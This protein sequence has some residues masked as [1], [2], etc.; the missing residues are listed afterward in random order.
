VPTTAR[1]T[2][3][4]STRLLLLALVPAIGALA[5]AAALLWYL[6]PSLLVSAASAPLLESAALLARHELAAIPGDAPLQPLV[7]RIAGREDLRLTVIAPDGTV[8]ADSEVDADRI[9]ALEN[10]ASRPE[11]REAL[12]SRRGRGSAARA[13]ATTGVD[14]VYAAVTFTAEDGT[15]R[16]LRLAEPIEQLGALRSRLLGALAAAAAVALAA[17]LALA[18]WLSRRLFHPLSEL[19]DGATRLA[20]GDFRHRL[21]APKE[22]A[23]DKLAGALNRL[24]STVE[25]QVAAVAAE[26]DHLREILASMAEGVVVTD[27]RGRANLANPAFAKLFGLRGEVA[28]KSL[29]ELTRL[30]LLAD[31]AQAALRDRQAITRELEL[32]A[33]A[34]R[35]LALAAAP[36]AGGQGAVI[37]VS[38]VTA[39]V[40]IAEMRRDF[41]A[42]V[43]HELKTPL[44]AIRGYAETLAD[45]ALEDQENAGRF[46]TRILDQCQRLQALLAD[47]LTLSR[48]ESIDRNAVSELVDCNELA[49]DAVEEV[50]PLAA[51][52]QVTVTWKGADLPALHGDAEGLERML[53]NLV[54]NAVKY[55]RRGGEVH[56]ELARRADQVVIEVRDTGIGI[57]EAALPRIFERF[58]RVDKGRSR[59]EG[60]TGLGLAIVKHAAQAHGGRVEV[61]SEPGQ[62]SVFRVVLPLSETWPGHTPAAAR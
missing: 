10:H 37:V 28:G 25:D 30:P 26:R 29:L 19:V 51:A 3:R 46:V 61:E 9:A 59:E 12:G 2:L 32:P 24:G 5:V 43:S 6:L 18:W 45:G 36:L 39:N 14:Y 44:A 50:L 55:N 31:L 7:E 62:G 11:V 27:A 8:L 1:S 34:R 23:L 54:D 41:V 53:V 60:G 15:L 57:P 35:N 21:T 33:P 48:L 49:R 22:E 42:N 52:R 38:D 40:R 13:S 58:Y 56:V 4:S 16:V 20:A 47:L 17:L